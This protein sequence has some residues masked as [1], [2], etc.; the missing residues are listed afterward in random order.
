MMARIDR[1]QENTDGCFDLADVS[2]TLTGL[3]T[4]FPLIIDPVN[5]VPFADH[6]F[7]NNLT[8]QGGGNE[9]VDAPGYD[10]LRNN[11]NERDV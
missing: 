5:G 11:T 2:W 8:A 9:A 1:G 7:G 4:V 3:P 6:S 10:F